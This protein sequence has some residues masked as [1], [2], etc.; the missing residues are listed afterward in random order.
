MELANGGNLEQYAESRTQDFVASE[1]KSRQQAQTPHSFT[2]KLLTYREIWS[3]FL[4]ICA[5]LDHLHRQGIVHRDLKPNNLLLRFFGQTGKG[6]IPRVLISDFGES[7]DFFSWKDTRHRTGATGTIEFTAPELL[8]RNANGQYFVE[9][10]PASDLWSLGMIL[11]YMCF[12]HLP[13]QNVDNIDLLRDEICGLRRYLL[14]I[15][16]I[17]RRGLIV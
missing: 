11:Y 12:S 15:A 3:F 17:C 2:K 13:Y 7:E 14:T 10:S 6:E 16:T 1:G 8:K 4:D 9:Y 5:G